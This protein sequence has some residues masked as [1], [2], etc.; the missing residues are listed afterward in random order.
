M[1]I[2]RGALKIKNAALIPSR[3]GSGDEL[4]E[5]KCFVTF[6]VSQLHND[7]TRHIRPKTLQDHQL[8]SMVLKL[9]NMFR[10]W[11]Y[12]PAQML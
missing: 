12:N 2:P 8:H 5:H 9:M 4:F 3:G 10:Y 1:R 11:H 6:T 7:T